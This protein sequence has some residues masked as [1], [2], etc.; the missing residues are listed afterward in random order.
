[1]SNKREERQKRVVSAKRRV[2]EHESKGGGRSTIKLPDGVSFFS[3]KTTG[4][5]RIDIIPYVV[6]KGNP[7]ADEGELHY[8]RTY[9]THRGV[10]ANNETYVCL[11]KTFKKKCFIC[12]YRAKLSVDDADNEMSEKE[13][14]KMVD[15]LRP[16]ERQLFNI[17]DNDDREKGI[18]VW[19]VSYFLFGKALDEHIKQADDD[20]QLDLF[21]DL[22]KGKT[23]KINVSESKMGSIAFMAFQSMSFKSR[24]EPLPDS[25]IDE[26]VCLDS[27]L[28]ELSFDQQKKA[29][30]QFTEEEEEEKP[31]KKVVV[32]DDEDED[33]ELVI[34]KPEKPVTKKLVKEPEP[35]E[36]D[37]EDDELVV[38][39]TVNKK[40]EEVKKA[41]KQG[42]YVYYK[43]EECEIT[44]IL[45]DGKKFNLETL[46]QKLIKGVAV[47]DVSFEAHPGEEDDDD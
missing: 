45:Q 41:P 21:A 36:E 34:K 4:P 37:D 39:P 8:E 40:K 29:F 3:V 25:L 5:K 22:E 20:E 32:E 10:G 26:A 35:E 6:G 28:V 33:D 12:E 18:Q 1:M 19:D 30:L 46:D 31:K 11:N 9:F 27:A 44:R 13:I 43:G 17:I 2:I 38:T 16:K 14:K 47:E 7:F 15:D 42:D 24:N 23:I